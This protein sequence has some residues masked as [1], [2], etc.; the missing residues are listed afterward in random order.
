MEVELGQGYE[1]SR[2]EAQEADHIKEFGSLS[3]SSDPS[4]M[5]ELEH[6]GGEL[7]EPDD[8]RGELQD[9][10]DFL[11]LEIKLHDHQALDDA[12][13]LEYEVEYLEEDVVEFDDHRF[14]SG[15]ELE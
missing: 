6:N 13:L 4:P 8:Y 2:E 7:E 15:N 9:P 5:A 12:E 3:D 10:E 14:K 11:D 1:D